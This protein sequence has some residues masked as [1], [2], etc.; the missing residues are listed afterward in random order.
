VNLNPK[1]DP[2]FGKPIREEQ[3]YPFLAD[4]TP[5]FKK[6]PPFLA[7]VLVP[8]VVPAEDAMKVACQILDAFLMV[9]DKYSVRPVD[10]ARNPLRIDSTMPMIGFDPDDPGEFFWIRPARFMCH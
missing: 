7:V 4:I 3:A 6:H 5:A 9:G 2:D 8:L 10:N 1:L